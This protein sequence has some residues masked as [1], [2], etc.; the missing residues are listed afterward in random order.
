[1]RPDSKELKS[2]YLY[3]FN[4][5]DNERFDIFNVLIWDANVD[6]YVQ[7]LDVESLNR[8]C[9]NIAYKG[10]VILRNWHNY[11]SYR[12]LLIKRFNKKR[13]ILKREA[14]TTILGCSFFPD[15]VG[16][17]VGFIL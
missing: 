11:N 15:I 9:F 5:L 3:F 16:C 17:I 1:M 12:S 6:N 13:E 2:K 4:L 8:S 10:Y 7:L 14:Y